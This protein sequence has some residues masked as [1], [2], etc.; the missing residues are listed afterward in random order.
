MIL[1]LIES[2]EFSTSGEAGWKWTLYIL[3]GFSWILF[4]LGSSIML[5]WLSI[6]EIT[7]GL[8]EETTG[9][10]LFLIAI[11]LIKQIIA[12]MATMTTTQIEIP[13]DI[14]ATLVPL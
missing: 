7:A 3:I 1:N 13:M 8:T 12:N 11:F 10:L 5:F 6:F 4:S 14:I 9:I 2:W